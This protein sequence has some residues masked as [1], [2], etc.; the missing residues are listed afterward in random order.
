MSNKA[1]FNNWLKPSN[2]IALAALVVTIIGVWGGM[3]IFT[4]KQVI[5]G[6]DGCYVDGV[7]QDKSGNGN[8]S[9]EVDCSNKSTITNIEQK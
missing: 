6:D 3:K 8:S 9:Q 4:N 1:W 2:L 7:L 5:K